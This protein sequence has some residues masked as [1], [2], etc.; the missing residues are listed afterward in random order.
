MLLL[1]IHRALERLIYGFAKLPPDG[2]LRLNLASRVQERV[3][4]INTTNNSS[5]DFRTSGP[6]YLLQRRPCRAILQN[7]LWSS[8]KRVMR[9]LQPFTKLMTVV[10][11]V[12]NKSKVNPSVGFLCLKASRI[13]QWAQGIKS[14][15]YVTL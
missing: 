5:C 1:A 3:L 2:R 13:T 4:V 9:C 11:P 8:R 14:K 7:V 6:S 10:P 12:S 15:L